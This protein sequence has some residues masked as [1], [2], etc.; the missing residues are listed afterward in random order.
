MIETD[1][2]VVM[3]DLHG[4]VDKLELAVSKY[5]SQDVHFV[6]LGD[7]IDG[8]MESKETLQLLK[9]IGATTLLGNH[10]YTLLA[11]ID[12]TQDQAKE[13]WQDVWKSD[14]K[15]FLPYERNLLKSYG[16]VPRQPTKNAAEELT[17][18]MQGLGHLEF[19]KNC[20][21]FF[22]QPD[23]IAIHAGLTEENWQTIQR[24]Y[25]EA[26]EQE[27][28]HNQDYSEEPVQIFDKKWQL[29]T[30]ISASPATN[31]IVISGHAHNLKSQDNVKNPKRV[32]IASRLDKG[33]PLF[34]WQ[35]WDEQVRAF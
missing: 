11:A 8:G 10:E 25:L 18:A 26:V 2:F 16:I 23:F 17:E 34:V 15:L 30:Q 21:L 12:E 3:P 6:Q 24:P 35:S 14:S 33:F 19:L 27:I 1:R 32:K 29:S 22:E 28:K 7:F 9:D 31:K 20:R 5:Q 4:R 13:A